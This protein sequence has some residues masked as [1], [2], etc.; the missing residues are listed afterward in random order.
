MS[1]LAIKWNYWKI[2]CHLFWDSKV[3]D[4]YGCLV[5]SLAIFPDL[6]KIL[7]DQ[8]N[9]TQGHLYYSQTTPTSCARTIKINPNI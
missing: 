7:L 6:L 5:V 3:K 4:M 2:I 8:S 1:H 9:V